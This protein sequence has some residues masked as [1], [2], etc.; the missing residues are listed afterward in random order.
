MKTQESSPEI[1]VAPHR[2]LKVVVSSGNVTL[3][4]KKKDGIEM[5]Y[6]LSGAAA[7]FN[8]DVKQFVSYQVV[9]NDLA[10]YETELT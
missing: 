6:D 9:V 5:T 10:D 8:E 4:L 1:S 2:H 7:C 3:H